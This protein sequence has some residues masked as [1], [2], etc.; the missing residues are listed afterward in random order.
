LSEYYRSSFR[1][2]TRDSVWS[3]FGTKSPRRC[4]FSLPS[5]QT[6]TEEGGGKKKKP[7]HLDFIAV[8]TPS[9]GF[10]RIEGNEPERGGGGGGRRAPGC[11][12]LS[13]APIRR[14]NAL[15]G[16]R[17]RKRGRG[18]LEVASTMLPLAENQTDIGEGKRRRE[19][20]GGREGTST[21]V[22]QFPFSKQLKLSRPEC[23][24]RKKKRRGKRRGH[25]LSGEHTLLGP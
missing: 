13:P 17:R 24:G 2:D 12:G 8:P 25:V 16:K 11:V 22:F 15:R 7:V 19:K 23:C 14:C 5:N 3:G 6:F 4:G 18:V 21:P 1:A 10:G 20:K 9:V